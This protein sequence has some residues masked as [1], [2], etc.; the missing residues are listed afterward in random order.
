MKEPS[1]GIIEYKSVARGIF[2]CDMMVKKAPIRIIET[3][4][5]CPGK[6]MTIICGEVADVEEA[7]SAGVAAGGDLTSDHLFLPHI[8]PSIIPALNAANDISQYHAISVIETF[9]TPLCIQAADIAAKTTPVQ[10]TEIRLA[11]G[12]GGKAYFIM[13]APLTDLQPAYEN[14]RNFISQQ[15]LLADAQIIPAPHRQLIEKTI[16]W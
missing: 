16:Y 11:N 12:L 15:G 3:H 4:P 8:H 5:I 10:I 6:Y 14:A 1:L 7:I 9:S 13:T 2:A